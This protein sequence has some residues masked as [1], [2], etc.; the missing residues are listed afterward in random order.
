MSLT[1][2]FW[3][4]T[5]EEVT[6]GYC[7]REHDYFCLLC[8]ESIEKG[9]IYPVE[10]RLYDAVKFTHHHIEEAHGSVFLYLSELDKKITGLSDHQN[11]LMR[12]FFQGK[13]DQEVQK[14]MGIGSASTIRNHRFALKEKERQAKV[15]LVMMELMKGTAKKS[16]ASAVVSDAPRPPKKKDE[17]LQVSSAEYAEITQ[18]YFPEGTLGRLEHYPRKLKHRLVVLEEITKR[19][20][21]K[22]IYSEKEVN[23]VLETAYEDYVTIR[24]YLIDHGFLDR[25]ADG[26]EYWVR[27]NGEEQE[28]QMNRK[29]ELKQMYREVKTE[30]GVYQIKNIQNGKVWVD[31]TKNLKT[32]NGKQFT[33]KHGSHTNKALQKE[34][35]EYGEDAFVF[36]VL[37][38]L[39]QKPDPFFDLADA[40]EKL[41][42]KWL[43]K[44]QP[45]GEKGYNEKKK[46]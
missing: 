20:D 16:P 22:K 10:G 13:S 33:L 2:Q 46:R 24:R 18:K 34:W 37:E 38:V 15:F 11:Q 28:K 32:M 1:E 12:L 42:N 30:A 44:L 35:N 5:F 21:P 40:L 25:A 4:A 6:Q 43:D 19:F 29:Q 31:A 3:S 23:A 39:E 41:E 8:G 17:E 36:E 45:Y 9:I 26:S 7:E 14:E 27:S